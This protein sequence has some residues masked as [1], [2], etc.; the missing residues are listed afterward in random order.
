MSRTANDNSISLRRIQNIIVVL[1][2]VVTGLLLYS[3]YVTSRNYRLF[4]DA[5]DRYTVLHDAADELMEASDYLTEMA[6]RFTDKGE[7]AY[8]DAYF[9][10]VFTARRR[11]QALEYMEGYPEC[12][13]ALEELKSALE[14]SNGLMEREYYA[15]KLVVEAK[16]ITD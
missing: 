4:S 9:Q 1:A 13:D 10:E 11:E 5:T 2:F 16:G 12:K 15:M 14:E 8:M 6:Q 7:R 3:T